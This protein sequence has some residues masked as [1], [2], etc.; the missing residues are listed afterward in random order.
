LAGL[1]ILFTIHLTLLTWL[2]QEIQYN[3]WKSAFPGTE[4]EQSLELTSWFLPMPFGTI[5]HP[6]ALSSFVHFLSFF[7]LFFPNYNSLMM[8]GSHASACPY[9]CS[10]KQ[11]H[12]SKVSHHLSL[13]FLLQVFHKIRDVFWRRNVNRLENDKSHPLMQRTLQSHSELGREGRINK[14]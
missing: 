13:Q 4:Q 2:V 9:L 14:P 6:S 5:S 10:R 8:W 7:G 11:V 3:C 12:S 1:Q